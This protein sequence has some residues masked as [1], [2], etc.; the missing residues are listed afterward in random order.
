MANC[1]VAC[2]FRS[3]S[4]AGAVHTLACEMD[5]APE[6]SSL[7]PYSQEL[8]NAVMAALPSWLTSRVARVAPNVEFDVDAVIARTEDFVGREL[9]ALL[10]TDVDD[11]RANPL[12]I[13]RASTQFVT[14]SLR[15]A[16]VTPAQRDDF[17]RQAMPDDIYAFG[18]LTW[19]D[20]SDD[21][22]DA[23]ITWGAWKA[24]TVLTRRRAEGKLS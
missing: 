5:S 3:S 18:P 14:A 12:H 13:L 4:V 17:D 19:K 24:A 21:V 1:F 22:H 20:L 10:Q 16:G 2:L 7:D 6:L 9:T 8:L 15:E 23:G 11:Q